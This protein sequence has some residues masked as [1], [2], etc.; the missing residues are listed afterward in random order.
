MGREKLGLSADA[1]RATS[2]STID[3]D[4]YTANA[5]IESTTTG[6]GTGRRWTLWGRMQSQSG[7]SEKVGVGSGKGTHSATT[8]MMHKMCILIAI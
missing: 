2:A 3:A 7:R 1:S 4:V 8:H 6:T 5:P